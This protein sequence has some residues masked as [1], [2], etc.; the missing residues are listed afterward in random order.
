VIRAAGGDRLA[1]SGGIMVISDLIVVRITSA[2]C[3]FLDA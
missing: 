3:A 2:Q 1:A